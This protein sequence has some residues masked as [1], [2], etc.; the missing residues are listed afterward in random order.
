MTENNY[1][2]TPL[3]EPIPIIEQVWPEGTIPLVHT[4]TKTFYHENYI[5]DCFE[6]ILMQ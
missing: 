5:R 1:K 3:I 2:Y 4:R 6:W